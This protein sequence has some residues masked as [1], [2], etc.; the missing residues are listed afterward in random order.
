MKNIQHKI[1][2]NAVFVLLFVFL[3]FPLCFIYSPSAQSAD[4]TP[5]KTREPGIDEGMLYYWL[6]FGKPIAD[7]IAETLGY[8]GTGFNV[9]PSNT[10]QIVSAIALQGIYGVT[11]TAG[12]KNYSSSVVEKMI[13]S[14]NIP[15]EAAPFVISAGSS[16]LS[17]PTQFAP[18]TLSGKTS[19]E[20]A[21]ISEPEDLPKIFLSGA[22]RA[23]NDIILSGLALA[24]A[25][26][27]D[28][29][30]PNSG[31]ML[32][33]QAGSRDIGKQSGTTTGSTSKQNVYAKAL[34][35]A[36]G[37]TTVPGNVKNAQ[38]GLQAWTQALL[39]FFNPDGGQVAVTTGVMASNIGK[40][41]AEQSVTSARVTGNA[42]PAGEIGR[43]SGYTDEKPGAALADIDDVNNLAIRNTVDNINNQANQI[44]NA[45]NHFGDGNLNNLVNQFSPDQFNDLF[46]SRFPSDSGGSGGGT[47]TPPVTPTAPDTTATTCKDST[48]GALTQQEVVNIADFMGLT[49]DTSGWTISYFKAE[50]F[51]GAEIYLEDSNSTQIVGSDL[52]PNPNACAWV[53]YAPNEGEGV[54]VVDERS[55][56]GIKFFFTMP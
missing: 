3:L 18:L 43:V 5:Q 50:K 12:V 19:A 53:V 40:K 41:E 38:G 45:K 52:I 46:N 35:G 29:S 28:N 34:S 25:G 20:K 49:L 22:N 24:A 9:N 13:E 30:L 21:K 48:A 16:S 1:I 17:L 31:D 39:A 55:Q 4:E 32:P 26:N 27:L 6:R 23:G 8:R 42:G 33:E 37:I 11:P 2:P 7:S 51:K 14:G 15:K 54:Y 47:Q 10:N 36:G 44:N 56:T